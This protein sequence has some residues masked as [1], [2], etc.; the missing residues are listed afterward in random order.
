MSETS[1]IGEPEV[2]EDVATHPA[3]IALKAA[4]TEL[5]PLQSQDGSVENDKAQAVTLV[6]TIIESVEALAPL[7][8]HDDDYLAA[9]CT[10]FHRWASA[11]LGVPDFLDSLEKFQPQQ[12][13]VDGLRHLVVFAMYTQNGS[14]DRLVE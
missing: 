8:P 10:D 5:Q 6:S 1:I 13:R 11:G 14:T 9:V 7:F 2:L 4:I 3:C 12:H